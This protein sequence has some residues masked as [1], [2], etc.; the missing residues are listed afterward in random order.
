MGSLEPSLEPCTAY[1]DCNKDLRTYIFTLYDVRPSSDDHG[2]MA[3]DERG[4][5]H[6]GFKTILCV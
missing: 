1:Y 6:E 2:I 3:D 5:L 4:I